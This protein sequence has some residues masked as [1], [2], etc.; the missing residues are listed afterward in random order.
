M[1]LKGKLPEAVESGR[2]EEPG[3]IQLTI[4]SELENVRLVAMC[5]SKLSVFAGFSEM[6]AFGIELCVVEAVTNAI[7]HAYGLVSGHEVKVAC[8]LGREGLEIRVCDRGTPMAPELLACA[9]REA[10]ECDPGNLE[11]LS[12]RG[13][14]LAIIKEIMDRVSYHS[15]GGENCLLMFKNLPAPEPATSQESRPEVVPAGGS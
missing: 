12:S 13:R 8:A 3:R 10:F 5:I 7:E 2:A 1:A 15:D 14:G 11:D 6:E 4:S 9:G